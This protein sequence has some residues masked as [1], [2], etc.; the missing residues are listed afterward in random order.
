M[1]NGE[2]CIYEMETLFQ[3]YKSL[4]PEKDF[5][6]LILTTAFG[7]VYGR[8]NSS[9]EAFVKIV[10]FLNFFHNKFLVYENNNE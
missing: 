6:N 4:L 3:K 10:E 2:K 9:P 7:V 1:N 8:S 5:V